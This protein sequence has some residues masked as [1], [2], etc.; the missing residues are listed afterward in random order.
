MNNNNGEPEYVTYDK[1]SF[2]RNLERLT[3]CQ[4]TNKGRGGYSSAEWYEAEQNTDLSGYDIAIIQLGVNDQIR[5]GEFGTTS[6]TAFTNIINKLK[7]ENKNIKIFVA[8]I[9]PATAYST[10]GYLTFSADLLE[11]VEGLHAN[12]TSIIPLNMQQYA[13]TADSS[14]YNCGH[15][16]AYGYWRLAQDYKNYISY[17][18]SSHKDE[19]REIQFIGTD[20]WYDDP[21]A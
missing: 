4:V 13:H 14:A 18:M 20:Y 10:E 16:S 5:Y 12:D 2:P 3:N 17:Y 7:T 8:N 21:N 15:L 11:W 1:Y 19:F 9:I 6:I